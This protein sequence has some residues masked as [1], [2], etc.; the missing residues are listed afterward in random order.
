MYVYPTFIIK[1][2]IILLEY[3]SI[4]IF[5]NFFHFNFTQKTLWHPFYFMPMFLHI[6]GYFWDLL[7]WCIWFIPSNSCTIFYKLN[8]IYLSSFL[9]S[10]SILMYIP[11]S[12]C[13]NVLEGPWSENQFFF[14]KGKY[15]S[16]QCYQNSCLN[17]IPKENLIM[18]L[19]PPLNIHTILGLLLSVPIKGRVEKYSEI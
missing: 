4:A 5:S 10:N 2:L 7:D 14:R 6:L 12:S 9:L 3:I 13:T 18:H 1:L 19:F 11:G 16:P 15:K 8:F 17:N